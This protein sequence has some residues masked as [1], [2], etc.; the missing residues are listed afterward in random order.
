MHYNVQVHVQKVREREEAR[1]SRGYVQ[2]QASSPVMLEKQVVNVLDL[3]VV[4][5]DEF[6][7]YSKAMAMIEAVRP[8][9]AAHEHRAS[10][11]DNIGNHLCGHP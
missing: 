1:D 4:A 2:M 7:A 3:S 11:D 10:C 6:G 8:N 5:D 9:P